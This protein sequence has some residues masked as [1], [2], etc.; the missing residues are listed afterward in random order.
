[1]DEKLI[2]KIEKLLN[3]G[4]GTSY[5]GEAETALKRAYELMQEN[6]ISM[7]DVGRISR[8]EK[9]GILGKTK[10]SEEEKQWRKWEMSLLASIARLFDCQTLRTSHNCWYDKKSS[11]AII[12]RESNRITAKLMFDWIHDKTKKEAR[13]LDPY[14]A[15]SRTAYCMGVASSIAKKVSEIKAQAPKTDAW[16]IVPVNEVTQWIKENIDNTRDASITP[17]RI[18]DAMAYQYG[19]AEG[20]K[21]SLNRQFGLTGIESRVAE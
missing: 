13:Y 8:D 10:M 5:A 19:R 1:M 7:E 20:N 17:S 3:L 14:H 4:N 9:L 21:L 15:S 12:G 18:R 11:L 16:G 2:R 6:N